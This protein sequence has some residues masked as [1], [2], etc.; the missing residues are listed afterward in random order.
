MR[1]RRSNPGGEVYIAIGGGILL[2]GLAGFYVY[3]SYKSSQAASQP[4]GGTAPA[5]T[6][7]SG[8]YAVNA[9]NERLRLR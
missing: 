2:A 6:T 9:V 8:M 7:T 5:A 4:S 1:R 3:S